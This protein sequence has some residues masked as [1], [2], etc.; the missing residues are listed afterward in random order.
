MG[1]LMLLRLSKKKGKGTVQ[2]LE[3]PSFP[4]ENS[5]ASLPCPSFQG[6]AGAN[7]HHYV[8]IGT[9]PNQLEKEGWEKPRFSVV[10]IHQ[11]GM[12]SSVCDWGT[13]PRL[14]ALHKPKFMERRTEQ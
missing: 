8:L 6:A 5:M 2:T 13:G 7:A 4:S 9:F 14:G 11:A 3:A 10:L 1:H 12:S